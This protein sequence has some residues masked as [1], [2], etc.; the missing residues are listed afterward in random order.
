[1][2]LN[3]LEWLFMLNLCRYAYALSIAWLLLK[4]AVNVGE[5]YTATKSYSIA[6][7]HCNNTAFLLTLN[8]TYQ[9]VARIYL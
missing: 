8:V 7:F 1:M 6:R 5:L 2:T 4:L 9:C 3:H